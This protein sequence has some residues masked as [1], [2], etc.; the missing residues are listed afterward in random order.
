[1]SGLKKFQV[2]TKYLDFL[3]LSCSVYPLE[4]DYKM[5]LLSNTLL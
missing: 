4:F 3:I 5:S 2:S 1:M